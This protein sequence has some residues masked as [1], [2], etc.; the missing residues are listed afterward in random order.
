MKSFLILPCLAFIILNATALFSVEYKYEQLDVSY[1]GC[2]S[3]NST[4]IAYGSEGTLT[5]SYN[6]GKDWTR[7]IVANSGEAIHSMKYSEGFYTGV[8]TKNSIIYSEDEG[9]EWKLISKLPVDSIVDITF[10]KNSIYIA[11]QTTI[12]TFDLQTRT[13]KDSLFN[14]NWKIAH[15]YRIPNNILVS[16]ANGKLWFHSYPSLQLEKTIDFK[17]LSF[18]TNCTAP[19]NVVYHN[20]TLYCLLD[21]SILYSVDKGLHWTLLSEF[22]GSFVVCNKGL[23]KT[24]TII[25]NPSKFLSVPVTYRFDAGSFKQVSSLSME[26]LTKHY[27]FTQVI[28]KG[29]DT[30]IG[31]GYNNTIF[32]SPDLGVTWHV[33]SNFSPYWSAKWLNSKTGF[34][35]GPEVG[36]IFR[37]TDGGA[38]WLPQLYNSATNTALTY[39]TNLYYDSTGFGLTMGRNLNDTMYYTKDFGETYYKTNLR[40]QLGFET[41]VFR[42]GERYSIFTSSLSNYSPGHLFYSAD[43]SFTEGKGRVIDSVWIV[44]IEKGV[45][46]TLWSWRVNYA[47]QSS[48][49]YVYST[50]YG[51]S[52]VI[53]RNY[54]NT[55]VNLRRGVGVFHNYNLKKI[56]KYILCIKDEGPLV[57]QVNVYTFDTDSG[58]WIND[59]IHLK[60]Y[61]AYSYFKINNRH[62]IQ[63]SPYKDTTRFFIGGE[64]LT[65]LAQWEIDTLLPVGLNSLQDSFENVVYWTFFQSKLYHL[66]KMSIDTSSITSAIENTEEYH[67]ALSSFP[68]YPNPANRVVHAHI[69]WDLSKE[70]SAKECVV[71]NTLGEIVERNE[72][73]TIDP[74]DTYHGVLTW[75]CAQV[76]AGAYYIQVRH[77]NAKMIIPVVVYSR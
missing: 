32:M 23:Y 70:F 26:R 42:F 1:S 65:N 30:L 20:D 21:Q 73:I 35:A 54:N 25:T 56:G 9:K 74:L 2:I 50:D 33:I 37:T 31:V 76:G 18:C 49:Q 17:Q 63:C 3:T 66:Y 55:R 46:D 69:Y 16:D 7:K 57:Q 59:S 13:F 40:F 64:S 43:T 28:L 75:N 12:Y 45:N 51:N 22:G 10:N 72:N 47:Y 15:L 24:S 27:F 36:R 44:S 58:V 77:G 11:T 62:Y 60:D 52:W 29:Q 6:D 53:V 8:T 61:A 14:S 19:S 71:Y 38:T 4:I 48:I 5:I 39:H 68:P 67:N 34:V 41:K